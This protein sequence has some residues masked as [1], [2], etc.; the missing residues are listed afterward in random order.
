MSP[1]INLVAFINSIVLCNTYLSLRSKFQV[2]EVK[3]K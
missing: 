1:V 3:S 2:I